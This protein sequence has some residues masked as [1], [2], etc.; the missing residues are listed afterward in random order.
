MVAE[1]A[2]DAPIF[3]DYVCRTTP[4]PCAPLPRPSFFS[5]AGVYLEST[6]QNGELSLGFADDAHYTG[7]ARK[8]AQCTHLIQPP[9]CSAGTPVYVPLTSETYWEAQLNSVSSGGLS[10]TST[11]K[12]IFDTGTSLLAGPSADVSKLASAVGC[13]V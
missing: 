8:A 6:G 9:P 5:L 11:P 3:G 12:G 7:E 4:E 2:L 13:K 1:G 10:F